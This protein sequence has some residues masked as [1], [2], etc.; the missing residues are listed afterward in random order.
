MLSAQLVSE[1]KH[2]LSISLFFI[3]I[4]DMSIKQGLNVTLEPRVSVKKQSQSP[5]LS[6]AFHS[7]MT[8]Q[9]DS[10]SLGLCGWIRAGYTLG[11]CRFDG[12]STCLHLSSWLLSPGKEATV[13]GRPE[14]SSPAQL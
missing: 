7:H 9:T 1:L 12:D 6:G 13:L 2:L 11:S 8:E 3:L 5:V 14:K 10:S 4:T